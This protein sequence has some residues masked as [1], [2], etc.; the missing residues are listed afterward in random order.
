[1]QVTQRCFLT[2]AIDGSI[3]G[4]LTVELW[5]KAAPKTVANFA[6]LCSGG[7]SGNG[8]RYKGASVFRAIPDLNIG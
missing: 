4:T 5:G 7:A 1:M 2:L 3:I 8:P 6:A